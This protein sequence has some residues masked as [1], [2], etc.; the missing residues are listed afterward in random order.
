MIGLV[1][2]HK[3]K[4]HTLKQSNNRAHLIL[5]L[6][7]HRKELILEGEDVA[8]FTTV[9]DDAEFEFDVI[10]LN[11]IEITSSAKENNF[12]YIDEEYSKMID[13][14]TPQYEWDEKLATFYEIKNILLEEGLIV[15]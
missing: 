14:R 13:E 6:V 10:D 9:K 12:Q 7:Q 2:R 5:T 4:E 3:G 8:L 1:I 15:E 11:K